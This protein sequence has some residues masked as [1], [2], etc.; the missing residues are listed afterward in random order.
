MDLELRQLR[1]FVAVIDEGTFT[2]AAIALG[3]SQASVS[4]AVAALESVLGARLLQRSTRHVALTV[5]GAHVIEH[6][7]RV[8]DEAAAIQRVVDHTSQELRVGYAWSALG[9]HTTKVQQRWAAEHPDAPLSF[10]HAYHPTAGLSDG[11]A[12]IGVVRRPLDDRRFAIALVGVEPRFATLP[13]S[14]PLARRRS[15]SLADFRGAT[16]AVDALTGTTTEDLWSGD[17]RPAGTRPIHGVD[18]FLIQVA[19]GQSI[20]ITSE[21]TARQYPR[22]GI[23]YLPV[24]DA[25]PVPVW[26]A[27]WKDDPPA[28]CQEFVRLVCEMYAAPDAAGRRR[29][30][31]R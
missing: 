10:V 9:R 27:W 23:R 31:R 3:L 11:T 5:T 30:A 1:S 4:R 24:R 16:I 29:P 15:I 13:T 18:E 19:A 28:R 6:A 25:P 26:L 17:A 12:D 21:G 22:P 2:D 7:R 8:L 14:H 20:G